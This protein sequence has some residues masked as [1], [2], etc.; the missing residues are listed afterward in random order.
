MT[1]QPSEIAKAFLTF[2]PMTHKKLQKLCFYAQ[3][4]YYHFFD[5]KLIDTRFE[6]WIHGPVSPTLYNLFRESGWMDI[7]KVESVRASFLDDKALNIVEEVFK[8]Y[9]RL[10]GDEL[11]A[12]T[13]AEKPWQIARGDIPPYQSSTNEISLASMKEFCQSVQA[14]SQPNV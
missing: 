1:Y 4:W 6:A 7:E 5:E 14:S 2:E 3:A 11:E 12:L 13:H 9:G 10:T 8:V